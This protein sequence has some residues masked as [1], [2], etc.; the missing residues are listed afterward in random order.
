MDQQHEI[1]WG[2]EFLRNRLWGPLSQNL[3]LKKTL[4]RLAFDRKN[5]R[6]AWLLSKRT[7]RTNECLGK[8]K[9]SQK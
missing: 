5:K 2:S 1:N 8:C 9:D 7:W 4:N 6:W 3:H